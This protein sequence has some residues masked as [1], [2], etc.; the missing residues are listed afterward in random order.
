MVTKERENRKI[1]KEEPEAFISQKK[2]YALFSDAKEYNENN[3]E[4]DQDNEFL[5]K[6]DEELDFKTDIK[7][8]DLV[9]LLDSTGSMNPYFKGVKLFIRKLVRDAVRCMTQYSFSSDDM[10]RVGLIC[11]RDHPPQG[12]SGDLFTAPFT[13]IIPDFKKVLQS[14]TAKGGGDDA[15]GV[16]DGLDAVINNLTWRDNSEKFVFH[17][18]DA[19]PHGSEYCSEKDGFPEGCPCGKDIESI[20]LKFRELNIDYTIIKLDKSIDKMVEIFSQYIEIDVFNHEFKKLTD[21]PV[22]QNN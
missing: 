9:F 16:I 14:I 2:A 4:S 8:V 11:Y 6:F 3:Y 13:H 20:L 7:G 15:E 22:D 10:L 12:K 1:Y 21:K 18:L 17:L 19:P 5:I